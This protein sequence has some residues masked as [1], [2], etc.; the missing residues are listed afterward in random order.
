MQ[1]LNGFRCMILLV[2]R[3]KNHKRRN[4]FNNTIFK[5]KIGICLQ[6]ILLKTQAKIHPN[7]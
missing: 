1:I 4:K 5:I 2:R 3:R 6:I 7:N